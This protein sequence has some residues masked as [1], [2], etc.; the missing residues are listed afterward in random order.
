[1]LYKYIVIPSSLFTEPQGI[2]NSE[3]GMAGGSINDISWNQ[4]KATQNI[5][6]RLLG[7]F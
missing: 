1:M 6:N 2:L 7:S 3:Y 5:T 4:Q